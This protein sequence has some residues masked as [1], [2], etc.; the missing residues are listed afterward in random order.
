MGVTN[1][2][3]PVNDW[4]TGVRADVVEMVTLPGARMDSLREKVN[5]PLTTA[6]QVSVVTDDNTCTTAYMA[7]VNQK[8]AGDTTQLGTIALIRVGSTRYVLQDLGRSA[9]EWE[10][11]DIY[12]ASFN[13]LAS[14]TR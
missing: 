2:C 10:L 11:L 4:T 14:V 3:Q 12:D 5:L 7:Q 13:Y 6:D 9:G 8:R 1:Y